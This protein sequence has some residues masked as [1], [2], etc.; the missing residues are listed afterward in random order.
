[1]TEDVA[2]QT[3]V[4]EKEKLLHLYDVRE[5]WQN[6]PEVPLDLTDRERIITDES[7]WR[8]IKQVKELD[9]SGYFKEEKLFGKFERPI[10]IKEL[11]EEYNRLH[12]LSRSNAETGLRSIASDIKKSFDPSNSLILLDSGSVKF[13]YH[14]IEN[15]L[16]DFGTAE[17]IDRTG[18]FEIKKRAKYT[19]EKVLEAK[20]VIYIDDWILS[21]QQFVNVAAQIIPKSQLYTYHLVMSDRGQYLYKKNSIEGKCVFRIKGDDPPEN[22][23]GEFPIYGFHKIP[24]RLP[25]IFAGSAKTTS[26][27][28]SIFPDINDWPVGRHSRLVDY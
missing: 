6:A 26:P 13:F 23:F 24:D 27:D 12:F 4:Y 25:E 21:G 19:G 10:L 22:Y 5:N 14:L 18:D 8:W 16:P 28:Y 2:S 17:E 11:L 9:Q 15:E 20:K 3:E 1:M 7:K